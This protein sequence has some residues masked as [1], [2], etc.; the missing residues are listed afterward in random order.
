[1]KASEQ[2]ENIYLLL[3]RFVTEPEE[4]SS[5]SHTEGRYLPAIIRDFKWNNLELTFVI[6]PARITNESGEDRHYFP[7]ERERLVEMALRELA[8]E[9]NINFRKNENTLDFTLS[10]LMN[11]LKDIT[12]NLKL[13][14]YPV[15]S[16]RFGILII[17]DVKFELHQPDS[18]SE[19]Y[20]RPIE[21]L[22]IREIDG[23]VYYRA[24]FSRLFFNKTEQFDFIFSLKN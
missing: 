10:E 11:A 7:G 16:V 13:E 15:D 17:G 23:E 9:P 21:R 18:D 19:L 3:P 8:I 22:V 5:S 14:S 2:T 12:G 4:I 24:Q 20:F 6:S 1:M